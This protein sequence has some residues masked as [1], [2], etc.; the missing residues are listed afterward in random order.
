MEKKIYTLPETQ[1][2]IIDPR[3][4]SIKHV[5][6]GEISPSFIDSLNLEKCYYE[7]ERTCFY[8]SPDTNLGSWT[9]E[10]RNVK[11]IFYGTTYILGLRADDAE[12]DV[13]FFFPPQIHQRYI[14]NYIFFK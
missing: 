9:F 10:D 14:S 5:S 8:S 4:R 1:A 3:Q 11:Q 12:S 6:T 13:E 7:E 2:T